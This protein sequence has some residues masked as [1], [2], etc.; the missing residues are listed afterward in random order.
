MTN[1]F[2]VLVFNNFHQIDHIQSSLRSTNPNSETCTKEN[3][4]HCQSFCK[5][6]IN[7][8]KIMLQS[9]LEIF[10]IE[11]KFFK[12][13]LSKNHLGMCPKSVLLKN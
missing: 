5:R 4:A 8:S 3:K 12:T 13:N 9:S 7:T 11:F 10:D 6:S 1:K 2:T